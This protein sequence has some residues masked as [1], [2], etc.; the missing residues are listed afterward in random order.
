MNNRRLIYLALEG[1][2]EGQASFAHVH[3][4][5]NGLRRRD[6]T[7][8]L[9][10]PRYS[11][12]W[13]RPMLFF[14]LAEYILVQWRLMR[15]YE[16]GQIIYVRSHFLSFPTALW[17]RLRGAPIIHE[18]NGP[19]EDVVLAYPWVRPFYGMISW[20]WRKQF[21][22]ADALI[23]VTPRL[24]DW[25]LGQIGPKP[26]TV[27]PNGAD[28]DLFRPDAARSISLPDRYAVFFGGL[29]RWQG[30]P[31]L[32]AAKRSPLWP[33]DVVLVIA[34]DGP[35]TASIQHAVTEDSGII[36]LGRI[37]YRTLPGIVAGSL[38]GLVPKNNF[39]NRTLTGLLPLKLFE[40]LAC[41]VPTV[42]TDFPGQADLIRDFDC[43]ITIPD[44][45][46]DS[47]AA[48]VARLAADP[49]E[50]KA[51]GRRGRD[52]IVSGHSWD[53]RAAQTSDTLETVRR[54]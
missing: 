11:H 27:I 19:Y 25:V 34:G 30:I 31:T 24:R 47:L 39:G 32:L 52:A 14:R 18:I 17:A 9:F 51:M 23:T 12:Q 10:V 7:V 49:A 6:W 54:S 35:E 42:V 8:D 46:P 44:G 43:G 26:I 13:N 21:K 29:A 28:T 22:W 48:A 41:G 2:V 4:I 15:A 5:C 37:P 50:A 38:C 40:T 16:E 3:E 1:P 20:I 33:A 45:N 36:H 53:V